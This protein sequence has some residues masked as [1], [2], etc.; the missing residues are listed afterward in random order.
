[1]RMGHNYV[2]IM[3]RLRLTES[4]HFIIML[5]ELCAVTGNCFIKCVSQI[6]WKLF[7]AKF[8]STLCKATHG[9]L[10]GDIMTDSS[11]LG[12]PHCFINVGLW[13]W[14]MCTFPVLNTMYMFCS[15][16]HFRN[17]SR[18]IKVVQNFWIKLTIAVSF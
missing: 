7:C 6:Y 11:N 4:V 2:Y 8:L 17:Q 12:V 1:M 14:N 15:N 3:G 16:L 9:P 10:R 5:W 13:C 18:A